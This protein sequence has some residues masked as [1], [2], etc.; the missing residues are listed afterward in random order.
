MQARLSLTAAQIR[1]ALSGDQVLLH[2]LCDELN[3]Y[4]VFREVSA[5]M[6]TAGLTAN[7]D[8]LFADSGLSLDALTLLAE[9]IVSE[10]SAS[11]DTLLTDFSKPL[12][13]T[14][15]SADDT[16]FA[17]SKLLDDAAV[18][19]DELAIA[20]SFVRTLDDSVA[21]ADDYTAAMLFPRSFDDGAL[22]FASD[23]VVSNYRNTGVSSGEYVEVLNCSSDALATASD[24]AL[25]DSTTTAEAVAYLT[26]FVREYT[27]SGSGV[28]NCYL[29]TDFSRPQDD[30]ARSEDGTTLVATF[31][32]SLTDAASSADTGAVQFVTYTYTPDSTYF[33]GD[34]VFAYTTAATF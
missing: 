33:A 1:A 2:A 6:D 5:S 10:A 16:A 11:A 8:R 32:R 14:T 26:G 20:S 21:S 23:Y 13:D 29:Q 18:S 25:F 15:L 3:Q 27:E 22:Y 4:P 17:P 12:S 34:Y 31:V 30:S 28:D 7:F 9:K 24:K 19:L